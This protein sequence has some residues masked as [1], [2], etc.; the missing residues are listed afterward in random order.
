[1]KKFQKTPINS[2]RILDAP[3][4][5]WVDRFCPSWSKPFLKLSRFD[6]PIGTWLLLLPCWWGSTF[7]ILS[8]SSEPTA[9]DYWIFFSCIFGSILMRGAGCTW[10]DISDQKYDA[11]VLRTRL[12][13]IPTGQISSTGAL[14]WML[15]QVFLALLILLT[16]NSVA[17][18]VGF[19]AII[20]V[21]IYPFAKRFTWW[22]QF[23]LG[24]AFNWGILL[25]FA[26]HTQTIELSIV[27]LYFS[28]IC[29]TIFY[30][31]IYAFQDS[32]D[33]ALIGLKSTALL[34]GQAAVKWLTAF[35]CL[36][37]VLMI[38]SFYIISETLSNTQLIIILS[39]IL[40]FSL[41]LFGQ[42][43]HFDSNNPALCLKLFKSNRNAGLILLSALVLS[44][45]SSN[46]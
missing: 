7:A 13:P 6:R 22:P 23:F 43:K 45:Y 1:M 44:I 2:G 15:L 12:R 4:F 21:L 16:F 46:I 40:V 32:N 11:K 41:H 26:A 31:T 20:P 36:S 37:C 18:V 10:N 34:F 33:D 5:N 42:L 35:V 9:H 30:D 38:C 17:I 3:K 8:V 14:I 28:A 27:L 19:I 24:I 39:G 25:S 29:W